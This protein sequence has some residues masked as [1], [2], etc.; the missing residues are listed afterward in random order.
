MNIYLKRWEKESNKEFFQSC[1]DRVGSILESRIL[2]TTSIK[3]M[4]CHIFLGFFCYRSLSLV[5]IKSQWVNSH[6]GTHLIS[7]S[8]CWSALVWGSWISS[9]WGRSLP[10]AITVISDFTAP[11]ASLMLA[12]TILQKGRSTSP[13]KSTAQFQ[14]LKAY[15]LALQD[16][17]SGNWSLFT[18]LLFKAIS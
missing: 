10:G 2:E 6:P 1:P 12:L 14:H 4:F 7:S 9:C 15:L 8:R 13:R 16:N 3:P 5:Q 17:Q 11:S 18:E